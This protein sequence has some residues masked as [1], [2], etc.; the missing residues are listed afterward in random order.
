ME[1]LTGEW[2]AKDDIVIRCGISVFTLL[3]SSLVEVL[4]IAS[5]GEGLNA[6]VLVKFDEQKIDWFS[7]S[8]LHSNFTK[9]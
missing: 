2:V 9:M 8:W 7:R 4:S 3:S 1:T 6:K 5:I